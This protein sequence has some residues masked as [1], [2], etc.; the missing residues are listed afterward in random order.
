MAAFSVLDPEQSYDIIDA[1]SGH[2]L[3][4]GIQGTDA[5]S[6]DWPDGAEAW[7]A[8]EDAFTGEPLDIAA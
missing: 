6:A 8:G 2:W 3:T 5:L 7:L 4:Q 1:V